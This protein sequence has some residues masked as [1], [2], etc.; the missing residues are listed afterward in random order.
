MK[1]THIVILILVAFFYPKNSYASHILDD[2]PQI[3][4]IFEV[5]DSL[6]YLKKFDSARELYQNANIYCSPSDR[7]STY[8]KY[9]VA[10]TYRF[11][12]DFTTFKQLISE[13]YPH[14][15]TLLN[16]LIEGEIFGL[17]QNLELGSKLEHYEVMVQNN[18]DNLN[19]W[20][21][22]KIYYN[23]SKIYRKNLSFSK[24]I[25][26]A[27]K[28]ITSKSTDPY[29]FDYATDGYIRSLIE[30]REHQRAVEIG[31]QFLNGNKG[32]IDTVLI[33][34]RIGHAYILLG[35]YDIALDMYLKR[36]NLVEKYNKDYYTDAYIEVGNCYLLTKQQEE[37]FRY[38]SKAYDLAHLEQ[39]DPMY[40]LTSIVGMLYYYTKIGEIEQTRPYLKELSIILRKEKFGKWMDLDAAVRLVVGWLRL[41]END[42]VISNAEYFLS[43]KNIYNSESWSDISKIVDYKSEAYYRLWK[44][45]SLDI[46][47]LLKSYKGFKEKIEMSQNIF[48]SLQ[49]KNVKYQNISIMKETYTKVIICGIDVFNATDSLEILHE[50]YNYVEDSKGLLFKQNLR[51]AQAINSSGI[52]LELEQLEGELNSKITCLR[53]NIDNFSS[54]EIEAEEGKR[55]IRELSKYVA[56]YDSLKNVF[57]KDY[58]NYYEL[59]NNSAKDA[60]HSALRKLAN[61]QIL[62]NYFIGEGRLFVF[63][64]SVKGETF[65]EL[66]VDKGFQ[67]ELIAYRHLIDNPERKKSYK[68]D[69]SEFVRQSYSLYKTLVEPIDSLIKDKRII[70]IP[71]EELNYVSFE[72]LITDTASDIKGLSYSNLNYLVKTNPI[73]ILYTGQQLAKSKQKIHARSEYVG[74]AP[75]YNKEINGYSN[76]DGASNEVR[77][78]SE[79][80]NGSNYIGQQANKINF[81]QEAPKYPIVH[82]ALHTVLNEEDPM[83]SQLLFSSENT[84]EIEPLYIYELLGHRFNSQLIVI[85]GCNSGYGKLYSGEGI[86][87]LA[88]TFFYSGID[89]AIVTQ[90][91]IADKS[92]SQLMNSFYENFS[93]GT[94]TD[95][96]LQ[97]AK[98]DFL[99]YAD[100]MRHHP[101]Y[102]AGYELVGDPVYYVKN[103]KLIYAIY[104]L[105]G[106][107]LMFIIVF[108]LKKAGR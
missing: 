106:M 93:C 48:N 26:Y 63:V 67:K 77:M 6:L 53:R 45:D 11:E 107:M 64:L 65:L 12:K 79:Y 22:S 81:L 73:S 71:Y 72:T 13:I 29:T 33:Y 90:W 40:S 8:I 100:P 49:T 52:P 96:A 74:F 102:W 105:G 42:K 3:K 14:S 82:L 97:K 83:F 44:K 80:Y 66:P 85:S 75:N 103:S 55:K 43:K 1:K 41:G 101:Y 86:L 54:A 35:K 36:L 24:S 17:D 28:I 60:F 58:S 92:S 4:H 95:I 88:R 50:I 56:S 57:E 91:A 46:S 2:Y 104:L 69:F 38:Y 94:S 34:S 16:L 51:N 10:D 25:M 37:A 15:D 20:E 32:F 23:L 31:L 27:Q 21:K 61:D 84:M 68:E 59:I 87:N 89:N 19:E 7:V 30:Q 62:V 99:K 108:Y 70:I 47:L 39:K 9:K 98:V 5:G 78:I 76:L 18:I